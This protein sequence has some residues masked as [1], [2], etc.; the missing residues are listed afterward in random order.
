MK[1]IKTELEGLYIV[2]LEGFK[3]HRGSFYRLY[4]ENEFKI[5]NHQKKIVQINHSS[6]KV[7]GTVR[8]MHF[9]YPP[10]SEIKIIKCLSGRVFDVAVDLRK[11]SPTFLKWF[12]IILTPANNKMIYIPEGFAHG[13]QTLEDDTE[14]LYLHT[15]FYD[16]S[17]EGGV[18]FDDPKLDIKW[19]L[20]P[21]NISE[22]DKNFKLIDNNFK[23]L[24]I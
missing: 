16:P 17:F 21:I 2:E 22:R 15:E 7:K 10:K 6:T 18:R 1:F 3:D 12:G 24:E 13:F 8:G 5:I 14:L 11:N 23:G 4:C 9:Q 19:P 20:K